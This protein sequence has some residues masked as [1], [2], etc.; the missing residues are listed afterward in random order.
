MKIEKYQTN[1]LS[2]ALAIF[3]EGLRPYIVDLLMKEG[4]EKW[5]DWFRAALYPDQQEG[6]DFS[7]QK[8]SKPE[9]Q[10]DYIHLKPFAL[11]Y[12]ELLKKDFKKEVNKLPTQ[13]E[14]IY[15]VRNKMAHYQDIESDEFNDVFIQMKKIAAVLEMPELSDEL[16]KLHE[17]QG[18]IYIQKEPDENETSS[19]KAWYQVV[20]PHLDIRQGLL[21]ESIFAADLNEVAL[22][23]GREIYTNPVVFFQKT[24]FTAGMRNVSRRLIQ[25]LNGAENGENRIISLQTGFGGGK[26]HT[27]I[28]LY[29][30]AKNASFLQ[31][32]PEMAQLLDFTGNANFHSA[33]L[34]VFTNETND[35][36]NGRISRDGLHI[37]T[38]WGDLAYQLGGKEAFEK[39]RK[40][41][42]LRSAPAGLFRE[43]L[44]KSNPAL[45]L[46]DE[47]ADYCVKASAIA[48]GNST[49]ADQTISFMQELSNA[50]RAVSN[51]VLVVTLPASIQEVSNSPQ[52]QSILDS[53]QKRVGR[54]SADTQPVAN[55]EIFEVIRRRLFEF[56]GSMS[57]RQAIAEEY[58]GLYQE[59][60]QDL[61]EGLNLPKYKERIIQAY[62]FHPELVDIFRNHWASFHNFQR[63]RGVLSLLAAIVSDLWKHRESL[64]SN[65]MLIHSGDLDLSRVTAV[66]SQIIK[67]FGN[68]YEAVMTADITGT[69][70]NAVKIDQ[71]NPAYGEWALARRVSTVILMRTFTGGETRK[72]ITIHDMKLN[73]VRPGGFN[74]NSINGVINV[75]E[76]SS[77][78]LH[79][80][81]AAGERKRYWFHIHPNINI[82]INQ[83]KDMV[84]DED[85]EQEIIQRLIDGTR[86]LRGFNVI[87][88]PADDIPE[89]KRPA[90]LIL[91][92]IFLAGSHDINGKLKPIIEK[93]ALRKGNSE[94]IYRNTILFLVASDLGIGRLKSVI[95]EYLATNRILSD[96]SL[97]LNNE[98]KL[99]INNKR[100]EANKQAGQ[101]LVNAYSI[102]VKYSG[103][104]GFEK[105]MIRDFAANMEQQISDKIFRL[106]KD[107]EWLLDGIGVSELQRHQLFPLPDK[108]IKVK[109]LYESFLRYND[110]PMLT[111]PDALAQSLLRYCQDGIF[112]IAA[113]DGESF[114]TVYYKQSV[115]FFD[116][117]E[118]SYWLVDKSLWKEPEAPKPPTSPPTDPT[119]PIGAGE[120][121]PGNPPLPP[122]SVPAN[123]RQLEIFGKIP[124]ENYS[125]LFS[126]FIM[127]LKENQLE[128]E[129]R[130]KGKSTY[131]KPIKKNDPLYNAIKEAAKQLGL[132]F[133]EE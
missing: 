91:S 107:E 123:V 90:L 69:L 127:P 51:C 98:Q 95:R 42:E 9:T 87:V 114:T 47:L 19:A 81:L 36:A 40:N 14:T 59:M 24:Y 79:S 80:N 101:S 108:P 97:N 89:Q 113:G 74:H 39:V 72:G 30:L 56:S 22:G 116:V 92:P 50:V 111:T 71:S 96:R 109:S 76:E 35:P 117:N 31:E 60:W 85:V 55:D 7:M 106:L 62:P 45:I 124:V 13:F 49:L 67:L 61:P 122:P 104:N 16:M 121:G 88:N 32:L 129:I 128:I 94:R 66:S 112:A 65:H 23:K 53:L 70:S 63:T 6:W 100:N 83:Y 103:K 10:I 52:T 48:C 41:D 118:E 5:P 43:I 18:A 28:T 29:H 3:I 4:G 8:G 110:K 54:M 38:I 105:L 126:S 77:Y 115:P 12:K 15:D 102:I 120:P 125:Q 44:E 84:K 34:A 73:L 27:L 75:L 25:G 119:K 2:A 133:I 99:D 20:K 86:L 57:M 33:N 11:K 37:Q 93:I 64:G 46:I 82:I 78:Y 1:H 21:D 68:G 58:L 26:T 17:A 130:I 132:K 131:T